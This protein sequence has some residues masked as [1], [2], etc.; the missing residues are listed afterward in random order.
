M[1]LTNIC[2]LGERHIRNETTLFRGNKTNPTQN[3]VRCYVP[4]AAWVCLGSTVAD[5]LVARFNCVINGSTSICYIVFNFVK[6]FSFFV[7]F[8][9]ALPCFRHRPQCCPPYCFGESLACCHEPPSAIDNIDASRILLN[10]EKPQASRLY[11]IQI[12]SNHL[13]IFHAAVDLSNG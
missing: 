13:T 10:Y 1:K 4:A 7:Y 3:L 12:S 9:D 5:N 2:D 11:S 8:I 6:L